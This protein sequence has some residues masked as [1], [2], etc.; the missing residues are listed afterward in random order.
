MASYAINDILSKELRVE[1]LKPGEIA[2]F[3]LHSV[4][5]YDPKFEGPVNMS[6]HRLVGMDLVYDPFDKEN[7]MKYIYNVKGVRPGDPKKGEAKDALFHDWA[8]VRFGKS[9]RIILNHTQN[10]QYQYMMRMNKNSSNPF[11]NTQAEKVFFLVNEKAEAQKSEKLFRWKS[12]AGIFVV[13][14]ESTQQIMDLAMRLNSFGKKHLQVGMQFGPVS[15]K[16][17]IEM[18]AQNYPADILL[19]SGEKK[20]VVDVL[21]DTAT[22][23]HWIVKEEGTNT[24][25][26]LRRTGEA[27]KKNIVKLDPKSEVSAEKQLIAFL[28]SDNANAAEHLAELKAKAC[29]HYAIPQIV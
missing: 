20:F 25:I 16:K 27:G 10:N 3:Q 21:V 5:I 8:Y 12:Y 22:S 13:E 29:Q 1:P 7:P 14:Q 23:Q 24:W 6:G 4:G 11:R 18:I 28:L 15:A 9:G 17:T 26:W 19:A 2:I